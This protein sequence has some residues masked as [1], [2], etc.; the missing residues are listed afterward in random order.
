MNIDQAA[1][2]VCYLLLVSYRFLPGQLQ[3]PLALAHL[4]VSDGDILLILADR[5]TVLSNFCSARS[6]TNV[7]AQ[8]SFVLL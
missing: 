2:S 3:I 5:R 4:F 7:L 8:F 6:A 1:N